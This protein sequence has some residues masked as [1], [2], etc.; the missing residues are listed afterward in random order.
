MKT[1][2]LIKIQC[3]KNSISM[4]QLAEKLNQSPESFLMKLDQEG[5][6]DQEIR[7]IA[8]VFGAEYVQEFKYGD[9]SSKEDEDKYYWM[10]VSKYI[11][12]QLGISVQKLPDNVYV[13]NQYEKLDDSAFSRINSLFRNVPHYALMLN[14]DKMTKDTYKVIYDRSKGTLQQTALN[15]N[16][17]RANIVEFGT[18]NKIKG[19]AELE[20]FELNLITPATAMLDIASIVTSQYYL[21]SINKK[22]ASIDKKIDSIQRFLE[23]SKRSSMWADG[24]FLKEVSDKI[25]EISQNEYYRMATLTS[26][27]SY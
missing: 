5:L 9:E 24:Q 14:A 10:L 19:H 13:D 27:T 3:S 4:E 26:V 17:F 1:S 15:K 20:K 6:S 22:L 2:D 8:E 25:Y 11:Y 23:E 16:R 12:N 18:N 7:Q 21:S